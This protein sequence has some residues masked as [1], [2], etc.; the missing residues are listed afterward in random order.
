[1]IHYEFG[2]DDYHSGEDFEYDPEPGEET[3]ALAS[4]MVDDYIHHLLHAQSKTVHKLSSDQID[5][6]RKAKKNLQSCIE[7][8]LD[9][10]DLVTDDLK[11]DMADQIKEY[12]EERAQEQWNNSKDY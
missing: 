7:Y 2:G 4:Y 8:I 11:D 3:E 9:S 12:L 6:I 10:Y 5:M 1:M